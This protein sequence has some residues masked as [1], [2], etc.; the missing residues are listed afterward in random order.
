[1]GYDGGAAATS[2][3]TTIHVY[4]SSSRAPIVVLVFQ[5]EHTMKR[6][7]RAL[8]AGGVLALALVRR[9]NGRAA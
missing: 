6:R 8:L 2:P 5:G 7:I 1:M 4:A 9:S 3:D